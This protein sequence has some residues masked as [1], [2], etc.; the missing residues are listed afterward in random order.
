MRP[1]PCVVTRLRLDPDVQRGSVH[2]TGNTCISD[3]LHHDLEFVCSKLREL[4]GY[5]CAEVDTPLD[6]CDAGDCVKVA[7]SEVE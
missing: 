1:Q 4:D 6:T 3:V 2:T 7:I 5:V